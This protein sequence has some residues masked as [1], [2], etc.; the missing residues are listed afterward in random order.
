MHKN[1]NTVAHQKSTTFHET[2]KQ[3][4]M[5]VCEAP[6]IKTYRSIK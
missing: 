4:V 5:I 2:L 1:D 6:E 3:Y